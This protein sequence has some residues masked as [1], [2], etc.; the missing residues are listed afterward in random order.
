MSALRTWIIP[1]IIVAL[2]V[3][4]EHEVCK[5]G[6]LLLDIDFGHGGRLLR[7]GKRKQ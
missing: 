3:L 2:A 5:G 4:A 7:A 6:Q 1:V